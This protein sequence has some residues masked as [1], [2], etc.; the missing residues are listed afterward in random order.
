MHIKALNKMYC[1]SKLIF[2]FGLL[3]YIQGEESKRE[4]MK[5]KLL[6]FPV[7][8]SVTYA[9]PADVT[10]STQP[11]SSQQ[12]QVNVPPVVAQPGNPQQPSCNNYP[13]PPPSS[14]YGPVPFGPLPFPPPPEIPPFGGPPGMP[15]P[16]FMT[17]SC[18][19]K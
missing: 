4:K 17:Q 9:R 12:P 5:I 16:P 15:P 14:P 11:P 6:L 13:P 3:F 8:I 2:F 1:F 10:V 19:G 7:L 18:N